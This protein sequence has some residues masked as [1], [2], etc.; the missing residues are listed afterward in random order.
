MTNL[1]IPEF[2]NITNLSITDLQNYNTPK[3]DIRYYYGSVCSQLNNYFIK[4]GLIII[5]LYIFICW[6]NWW[7]FNY[8][9]KH[10]NNFIFLTFDEKSK[11]RKYIGDLDNLNTRIYWD[12]WIKN[13]LMK[14]MVGYITVVVYL[15]FKLK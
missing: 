9:Y 15:N 2:L 5:C 4:T 13:K 7:F 11:I 14:L 1:S 6:F 10:F 8:G 3:M 12:I